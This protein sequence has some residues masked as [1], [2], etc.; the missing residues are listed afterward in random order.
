MCIT[1]KYILTVETKIEL[2]CIAIISNSWLS[3]SVCSIPDE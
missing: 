3:F 1:E 2:N